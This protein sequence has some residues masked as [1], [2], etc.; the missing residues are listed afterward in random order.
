MSFGWHANEIWVC[1]AKNRL[2]KKKKKKS[3]ELSNEFSQKNYICSPSL[4]LGKRPFEKYFK[5]F[6]R[7]EEMN[8]LY[9]Q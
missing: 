9:Y 2:F 1:E 5:I 8:T 6:L 3:L 4:P 7:N